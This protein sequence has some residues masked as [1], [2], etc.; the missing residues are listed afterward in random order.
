MEHRAFWPVI[1]GFI[2]GAIIILN[3]PRE[4][5]VSDEAAEAEAEA[6]EVK[7]DEKATK[8]E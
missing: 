1:L 4:K 8:L 7:I 2:F 5:G 3:V 6:H